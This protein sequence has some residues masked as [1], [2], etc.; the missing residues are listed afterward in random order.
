MLAQYGGNYHGGQG[1]C[2]RAPAERWP[3]ASGRHS[4]GFDRLGFSGQCQGRNLPALR[5]F[6]EMV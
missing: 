5:T 3:D 6:S 1:S 4:G 2:Q